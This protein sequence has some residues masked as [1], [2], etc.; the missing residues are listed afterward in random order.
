MKQ[1]VHEHFPNL[2]HYIDTTSAKISQSAAAKSKYKIL[3]A[4]HHGLRMEYFN[5]Y[6]WMVMTVR[7]PTGQFNVIFSVHY[8][9]VSRIEN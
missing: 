9:R 3:S 7:L 4:D 2:I 8:S 1:N 6:Y 5:M